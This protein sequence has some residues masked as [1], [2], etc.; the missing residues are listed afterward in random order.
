MLIR[1]TAA[2]RLEQRW[3][4]AVA[5]NGVATPQPSIVAIDH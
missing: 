3:H 2:E 4:T 5:A 1:R